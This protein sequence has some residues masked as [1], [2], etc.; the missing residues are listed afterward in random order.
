[1]TTLTALALIIAVA[2]AGVAVVACRHA[3]RARREYLAALRVV[4]EQSAHNA[5]TWEGIVNA[6]DMLREHGR[7]IDARA[8]EQLDIAQQRWDAAI[9]LVDATDQADLIEA[10]IDLG[11][12]IVTVAAAD[13]AA[14][15]AAHI[16]DQAETVELEV[17]AI[18][19]GAR[20]IRVTGLGPDIASIA[21]N[22]NRVDPSFI[23]HLATPGV[24]AVTGL[25]GSIA[26]AR[27]VVG[28]PSE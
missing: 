11:P 5:E 21:F 10:D 13:I 7:D 15:A 20:K 17:P 12:Q 14:A 8:T 3:G 23:A 26:D 6:L 9:G 2:A 24:V 25:P 1:M 4:Q 27:I 18:A 16:A 19:G 22:G 28:S